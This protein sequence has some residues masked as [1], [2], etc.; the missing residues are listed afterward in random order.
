M[1]FDGP[2]A[3]EFER[4]DD[5]GGEFRVVLNARELVFFGGML[6]KPRGK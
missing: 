4:G 3:A 1:G 6:D 5:F 2:F